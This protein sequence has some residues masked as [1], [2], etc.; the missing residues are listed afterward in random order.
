MEITRYKNRESGYDY[1]FTQN[2]KTLRIVFGG[3]LDLYWSLET[4][5]EY[6]SYEDMI[7]EL[8]DT[9]LITKENYQ[10]Y[11][12]FKKLIDDVKNSNVYT[13]SPEYKTDED[14]ELI[15]VPPSPKQLKEVKERNEELKNR[16]GYKRIISGDS[17]IWH[18]DDES[19]DIADTLKISEIDDKI[20]L[21][22][23]RPELTGEK[24]AIRR[25]NVI[26]IRFRNSGSYYLP[27]N[28]VF[29]RMYNELQSFDPEL[30]YECHQI[31]FEELPYQLKRGIK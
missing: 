2:N 27:Y 31:H 10:I 16:E 25:P 23:Y 29:M 3:N 14:E 18:S 4:N 12:L 30:D 19:I 11:S 5:Q 6:N 17:L 28:V 21:E 7:K 9:F 22:F 1:E 26:S 20:L 8:Y 15:Q 13:P 24:S